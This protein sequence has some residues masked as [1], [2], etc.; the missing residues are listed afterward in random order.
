MHDQVDY[1]MTQG[2]REIA[3]DSGTG[4]TILVSDEKRRAVKFNFDPAYDQFVSIAESQSLG[5]FP[6]IY[7]H[8]LGTFESGPLAE[9][10]YT[11]T[12]MELLEPLS[13]EEQA[14]VV[15]W[16]ESIYIARRSGMPLD[17]IEADPFGLLEAVAILFSFAAE[18]GVGLDLGKGT[19]YMVRSGSES[20]EFVI[21]D[22]FN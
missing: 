5:A 8:A 14:N 3:T 4:S 6:K 9:R 13:V 21:T 11:I 2:F 19:N 17:S 12:E 18:N 10:R 7:K 22:P 20:R 16:I 1:Y 15:S